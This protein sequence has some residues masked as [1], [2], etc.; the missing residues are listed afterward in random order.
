[1]IKLYFYTNLAVAATTL[2]PTTSP[3]TVASSTNSTAVKPSSS[4]IAKI[5]KTS[6]T[7]TVLK[8]IPTRVKPSSSS[9]PKL[10]KTTNSVW[11]KND[12]TTSI[13]ESSVNL[14]TSY[15]TSTVTPHGST[16]CHFT[17]TRISLI[18]LSV[19]SFT[20]FC[21]LSICMLWQRKK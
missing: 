11:Q 12:S 16:T 5:A 13:S 1:M 4:S 21:I 19:L 8:E 2:S 14:V 7:A 9:I 18:G 3:P 15:T 17:L 20:L 6:S 10:A